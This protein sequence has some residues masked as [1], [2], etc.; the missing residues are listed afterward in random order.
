VAVHRGPHNCLDADHRPNCD[1]PPCPPPPSLYPSLPLS[2]YRQALEWPFTEACAARF[3]RPLNLPVESEDALRCQRPK[4]LK[5]FLPGSEVCSS[6][7]QLSGSEDA[8]SGTIYTC[9]SGRHKLA[10][11]HVSQVGGHGARFRQGHPWSSEYGTF[12]E[13]KFQIRNVFRVHLRFLWYKF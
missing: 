11:C 13:R 3:C 6:G 7:C 1:D 8:L 4:T 9:H 10:A 5:E 2:P 12:M